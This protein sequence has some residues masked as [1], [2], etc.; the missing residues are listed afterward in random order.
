V[1]YTWLKNDELNSRTSELV[2]LSNYNLSDFSREMS[3][4]GVDMPSNIQ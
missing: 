3:A 2:E 1:Y 4:E